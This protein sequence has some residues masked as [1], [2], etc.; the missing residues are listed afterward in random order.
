MKRG[1][2]WPLAGVVGLM[3]AVSLVVIPALGDGPITTDVGTLRLHLNSDGDRVV[4]D[5]DAPGA[6]LVQNLSQTNC[7]LGSNNLLTIVGSGTQLN[8]QPF[9]G[10]KDHRIGVGQKGEGSG[11]PCARINQ[12]FGQ[13]LTL[14]PT[15]VLDGMAIDYAELDLGFK[16]DG[17]AAP[18]VVH[19]EASPSAAQ[20]PWI[21]ALNP[22]AV[23]TPAGTT[24][25]G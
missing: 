13:T 24:T 19:G 7:K 6:N 10:L 9:A 21:A 5:P 25:F 22:T 3:V 2:R 11:E 15:G 1:V 12:S 18:R 14:S 17:D 23:P 8:K 20:L 4:F 16:F